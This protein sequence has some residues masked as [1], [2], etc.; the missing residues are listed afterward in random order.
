MMREC[1]LALTATPNTQPCW[2]AEPFFP[3]LLPVG[4]AA[5]VTSA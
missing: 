1:N 4:C 3:C 5:H 2:S